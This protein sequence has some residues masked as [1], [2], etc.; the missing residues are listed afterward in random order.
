VAGFNERKEP[1]S[2]KRISVRIPG[3]FNL[4]DELTVFETWNCP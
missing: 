3:S 1:I 2:G 4:I